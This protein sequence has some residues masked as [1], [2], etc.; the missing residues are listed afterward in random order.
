MS[1]KGMFPAND[2][3]ATW[4][5]FVPVGLLFPSPIR[6]IALEGDPAMGVTCPPLIAPILAMRVSLPSNT[7]SSK[8]A[9]LKVAEVEP[10]GMSTDATEVK[11]LPSLAT[12]AKLMPTVRFEPTGATVALRVH[13]AKSPSVTSPSL[14]IVTTESTY[15]TTTT[16]L[17]L[18]EAEPSETVKSKPPVTG[19][20]SPANSINSSFTSSCVKVSFNPR[21]PFTA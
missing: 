18:S 10:T 15:F 4:A 12:P 2:P 9:T 17:P 21:G 8:A 6:T 5:K 20:A 1:F 7:P 13:S 16:K 14:V 19:E 3:T 11:S